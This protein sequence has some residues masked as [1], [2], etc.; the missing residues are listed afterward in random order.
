MP[1]TMRQTPVVKDF[2][3]Q[4]IALDGQSYNAED[5]T[6]SHIF[7]DKDHTHLLINLAP[8]VTLP[9]GKVGTIRLSTMLDANL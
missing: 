6:Y 9:R 1:V 8:K 2:S 3:I 4:S 5:F 7:N